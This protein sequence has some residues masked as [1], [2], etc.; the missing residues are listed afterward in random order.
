VNGILVPPGDLEKLAAALA[1][2][3]G[4]RA[5]RRVMGEAAGARAAGFG[6]EAMVQA[7]ADLFERM[8]WVKS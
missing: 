3:A 1:S 2:L 5:R 7:Y 6:V 8:R 4:D